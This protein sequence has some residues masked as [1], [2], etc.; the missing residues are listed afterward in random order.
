MNTFQK[1]L[2]N[3]KKA[4]IALTTLFHP[5][6]KS[7]DFDLLTI[8]SDR[9]DWITIR[10]VKRLHISLGVNVEHGFM[11]PKITLE[12][13]Q[14]KYIKNELIMKAWRFWDDRYNKEGVSDHRN[15]TGLLLRHNIDFTKP[16]ELLEFYY[17]D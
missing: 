7:R 14:D 4:I 13:F 12:H 1:S 15:V 16:M 17:R 3:N 10:S 8:S 9:Y 11:G 6:F 2:K 5:S